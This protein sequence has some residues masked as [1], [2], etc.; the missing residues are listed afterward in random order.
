M[1][2][3]KTSP[4]RQAIREDVAEAQ[5]QE[6]ALPKVPGS[7]VLIGF[8][9]FLVAAVIQFWP[10][11]PFPYREGQIAPYD[12]RAPVEFSAIDPVRAEQQREAARAS[13]PPVLVARTDQFNR[14]HNQ[15]S[16]LKNDADNIHAVAGLSPEV[17]ARFPGLTDAAL[18]SIHSIPAD[19]FEREIDTF[20]GLGLPRVPL[21]SKADGEALR[22]KNY[23]EVSLARSESIDGLITSNEFFVAG[24]ELDSAK[25]R[26]A[27]IGDFPGQLTVPLTNFILAMKEPTYEFNPKLSAALADRIAERAGK[28]AVGDISENAVI[29]KRGE[30]ITGQE[31]RQLL[32]A[33]NEF[34]PQAGGGASVGDLAV[35]D[36]ADA[37]GAA[38]DGGGGVVCVADDGWGGG[39]KG[40]RQSWAIC[41]HLLLMLIVA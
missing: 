18:Q 32:E 1:W 3:K 36:R 23:T 19:T 5:S 40:G 38:G 29:V 14:I 39:V 25:A 26:L 35:A 27:V 6:G 15:L 24:E 7:I 34:Q 9:F 21:V 31:Y 22:T 30:P 2:F 41:G 33:N 12:L 17:Q 37:G 28:T 4:R 13:A 16:S 8:V 20:I 11:E 10:G